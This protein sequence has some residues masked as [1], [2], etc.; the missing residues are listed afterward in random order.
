MS[1]LSVQIQRL[2]ILVALPPALAAI[3]VVDVAAYFGGLLYWYGPVMVLSSPPIWVWPFLPDC[4][5]FGL[6]GGL[7]LLVV[8]A[9][10]FWPEST[11]IRAQ[12]QL[13][14]VGGLSAVLWLSTYLPGISWGWQTQQAMLGLWAWSLLLAGMLF[15]RPPAWLLA[16]I[17][18]GQIKYGVW[19]VTAWLLFW[20]NT[21]AELG[22]PLFTF[23]SVFMTITHL[24]LIAQ[25]VLLLTYFKPTWPAALV[26]FAWFALS[27]FVD[28]GLGWYPSLPLRWIPLAVM[29]WS[30]VAM[31]F[32]LT[33]LLLWLSHRSAT[34][35]L[36]GAQDTTPWAARST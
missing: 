32:L 5:L 16:I 23:D 30:T 21:A 1:W 9:Q 12:R 15:R 20:K 27:D 19:T 36:V 18:A 29:Q 2:Q 14:I 33:G 28:Y 8:T 7:G 24:G 4:P 34:R 10:R 17:A 11:Q 26:T 25:G 3:L 22:A 6:L 13:L 31:T 35:P